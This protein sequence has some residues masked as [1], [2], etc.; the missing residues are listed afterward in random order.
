LRLYQIYRPALESHTSDQTAP[1][2]TD[3]STLVSYS[4][5]QSPIVAVPLK[6]CCQIGHFLNVIMKMFT[7]LEWRKTFILLAEP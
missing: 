4:T 2:V 3:R 6:H 1:F 5:A 7:K